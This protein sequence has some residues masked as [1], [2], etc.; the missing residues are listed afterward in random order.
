MKKILIFYLVG[1][2]L[3]VGC[4]TVPITGRFQLNMM[5]DEE[6]IAAANENFSNFMTFARQKNV[7]LSASES[8]QAA[9][10]LASV[11]RISGQIIEAS[12]L[13]NRLN[14]ET[15]VVRASNANAFVLPNGKIVVFTGI[16]PL[17]KTDAGLATVIAHEVAHVVAHHQA[18]RIS[19]ALLAKVALTAT[20]V[21][22]AVSNSKYRPAIGAALE[23]GAQYGVLMPFS[24]VHESEAD[25]IALIYMAKAGYDPTEAIGFW[26]RM[27]AE[28]R[29]GPWE[30]LSTHPSPRTRRSNIRKW[31]HEA[32]IYYTDRTR[33]LQL[34]AARTE[35]SSRVALAPVAY[36]PSFQPGFW[37]QSKAS[38]LPNPTT[39]RFDRT[40]TCST[41]ECIVLVDDKGGATI[42]TAD[43]GVKEYRNPNGSCQRF[44]PALR[45]IRFPLRVGDSWTD[46]VT[47]EGST[48]SSKNA[49]LKFNAK[50]VDYESVTVPAGSFMAFKI[51]ASLEGFRFLELWYAPET[52]THV[53]IIAYHPQ[54]GQILVN[55]LINYQKTGEPIIPINTNAE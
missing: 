6:V 43:Y 11:G 19:Q 20:E 26:E 15:V 9:A 5:S 47:F 3:L 28:G 33:Q 24:R 39:S 34:K 46:T 48:G 1:V 4:A 35:Q 53:R 54:K 49:Q 38:N 44:S 2:S 30:L 50:V 29:S 31:L 51:I 18:E 13:R 40:E 27:E 23:L 45:L 10:I 7:V 36:R 41:G 17:A 14:W 12:G 8:P 32:N 37:Y 21:A 52:R 42:F 25:H 16:L 55:E 22:L